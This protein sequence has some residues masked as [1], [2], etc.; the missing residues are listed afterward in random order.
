MSKRKI[1]IFY[2]ICSTI[3]ILSLLSSLFIPIWFQYCYWDFGLIYAKSF[4]SIKDFNQETSIVAVQGDA[5]GS[6]RHLLNKSCDDVCEHVNNIR[7]GGILLAG[8]ILASCIASMICIFFH[9]R[10][11]NDPGLKVKSITLFIFFPF[12]FLTIG[13][14]LYV[15]LCDFLNINNKGSFGNI[16]RKFS[17]KEGF[18]MAICN[19]ALCLFTLL[20]GFKKSRKVISGKIS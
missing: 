20:F 14:A 4:T 1:L 2:I 3:N 17:L 5:C 10:V 19:Y 18:L 15:G 8:F 16:S 11:L 13:F 9:A 7:I 12:L 6:L